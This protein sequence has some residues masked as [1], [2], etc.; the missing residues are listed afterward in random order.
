MTL[1]VSG[2]LST[3][4]I[5]EDEAWLAM[6][7]SGRINCIARRIITMAIRIF[8]KRLM[9]IL[10]LLLL[11]HKLPFLYHM[12]GSTISGFIMLG[13]PSV[14]YTHLQPTRRTPISYAV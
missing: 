3:P 6:L 11:H 14:S 12:E 2:T 13:L 1:T 9:A 10:I 4:D 5:S 8:L 7:R